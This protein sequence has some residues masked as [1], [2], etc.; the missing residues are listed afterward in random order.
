MARDARRGARSSSWNPLA[1]DAVVQ[2]VPGPVLGDARER[3]LLEIGGQQ[4]AVKE[5]T[6]AMT[7]YQEMLFGES[8]TRPEVREKWKA[9]LRQYC[10]LD[11]LAMV[12][13]FRHWLNG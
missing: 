8:S 6:G 9:L 1:D 13:V 3:Q 10:E 12:V 2:R 5:G 11:T 4:Q 7:A